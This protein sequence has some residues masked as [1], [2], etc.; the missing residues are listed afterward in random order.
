M[1]AE[2]LSSVGLHFEYLRVDARGEV[3]ARQQR[4]VQ[5]CEVSLGGGAA[6]EMV[7]IP[8]GSFV[9]GSGHGQG[10]PDEEP[11]HRVRV[12]PFLL[13]RLPVT[14]AQWQAV[15]GG[16]LPWRGKGPLKPV[17]NVTW[18]ESRA[19]C[20]R[21]ASL[22]GRRV[23]LPCEAEWEYACRADTTT[24]FSCGETITTD[25]ANYVGEWTFRD[26]KPGV[27]RHSSTD[28]GSFAPN[29][30]GLCDMHGNV[31]EWCADRWHAGYTEAPAVAKPWIHAGE[32]GFRV[33]RGGSWHEPPMNCRCATRLR[34]NEREGE[35]LIGFR[36]AMDAEDRPG[37][38]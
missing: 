38:N 36:V 8:A 16:P 33:V 14:Q 37:R 4:Q 27:Y 26:E 28:A 3:V 32:P 11:A 6:I 21:L 12:G 19:F 15:M 5:A 1:S 20:R 9:M 7:A 31:W 18:R 24:P 23:R 2:R 25:L 29:P 10:Y 35:D 30:Y 34:A 17:D 13:G 22:T